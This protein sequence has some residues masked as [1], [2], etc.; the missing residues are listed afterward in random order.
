[1]GLS[2]RQ[3]PGTSLYQLTAREPTSTSA[4]PR[5]LP[6][7]VPLLQARGQSWGPPSGWADRRSSSRPSPAST[8][9]SWG[10]PCRWRSWTLT[11]WSSPDPTYPSPRE[12]PGPAPP[13]RDQWLYPPPPGYHPHLQSGSTPASS[14][15]T[16]PAES[17]R[18]A[19]LTWESPPASVSPDTGGRITGCRARV[20]LQTF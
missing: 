15:T 4:P 9:R 6:P 10:P 12:G 3:D 17:S 14:A 7:P 5:L 2:L 20:S 8:A 16:R 1:M 11:G 13:A 19:K 18:S